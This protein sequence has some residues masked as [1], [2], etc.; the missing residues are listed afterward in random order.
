[1][2]QAQAVL[3]LENARLLEELTVTG[4]HSRRLAQRIINAQEKER[5]RLSPAPHN[6]AGQTLTA[7]HISLELLREDLAD[8]ATTFSERVS[9]AIA[10]T[11]ETT[12]RLRPLARDLRPP[13]LEAMDL[14]QALES[15]CRDF[16]RRTQIPV[17]CF[18]AETPPLPEPVSITLYRFLQEALTNAARHARPSH[19]HMTLCCDDEAITLSVEDDGQGFDGQAMLSARE[20]SPG[21]GLLGIQERLEM[22]G[23]R[24][25]IESQPG[26][27][28]RLVG[29]VP[30]QN[31][32]LE[33]G[34]NR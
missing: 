13:D 34:K 10:L 22:L 18:G 20:L 1:L 2:F 32:G 5:Q 30:L 15:V 16:A 23:G 33:S 11:T 12:E 4:E 25:E 31:A 26:R 17:D 8:E 14:D 28:T 19:I 3:A 6:E 21:S 29:R 9:D 7:L 24:L 27:G